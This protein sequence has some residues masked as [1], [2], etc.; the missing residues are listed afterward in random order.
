MPDFAFVSKVERAR[1]P[2]F[3]EHFFILSGHPVFI[4]LIP[5]PSGGVNPGDIVSFKPS[6]HAFVYHSHEIVVPHQ[7]VSSLVQIRARQRLVDCGKVEV[8]GD[9]ANHFILIC[10]SPHSRGKAEVRQI[11][12]R[13]KVDWV[14]D[15]PSSRLIRGSEWF[16]RRALG[17]LIPGPADR[18]VGT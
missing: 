18:I 4:Y 10:A 9:H 7:H 12:A 11:C 3:C 13:V 17:S 14:E 5:A 2:A 1:H 6:L 8:H 15:H 16:W